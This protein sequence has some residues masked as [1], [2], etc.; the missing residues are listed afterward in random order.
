[1]GYNGGGG[2]GKER[3]WGDVRGE[4]KGKD[5]RKEEGKKTG[6]TGW[7][8]RETGRREKAETEATRASEVTDTSQ[9][10]SGRRVTAALKA[11]EALTSRNINTHT[12]TLTE[13]PITKSDHRIHQCWSLT[14][15]RSQRG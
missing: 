7:E 1:M 14:H 11:R 3:E 5:R 15:T 2:G 8:R 13:I 4:R 10:S 12:H 6:V 9:G